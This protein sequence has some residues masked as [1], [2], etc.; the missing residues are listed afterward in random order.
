MITQEERKIIR[1]LAVRLKDLSLQPVMQERK[2]AWY[3]HNDL[4]STK[5]LL[6]VFPEG[7]WREII[8]P[9]MLLCEDEQARRMEWLLRARLYRAENINDDSAVEDI[10]EVE[11]IITDSGWGVRKAGERN[12][13]LGN[14]S[15]IDSA[16]GYTL[17]VWEKDFAFNGN[18]MPFNPLIEGP[19]DLKK[20]KAPLVSYDE[21]RTLEKFQIEQDIL[22]DILDVRLVEK[23]YIIFNLMEMYTDLRGLENVLYDLYEE[24]QMTHEAMHIFEEGFR[25]M[26]R[27][28]QEMDLLELNNDFCYVGTGGVGYT[29]ELPQND[30]GAADL[31]NLWALA[32]SQE[33][34]SVS[35]Q[36]H[37]EFVMQY[38]RRLLE[39]FGLAAYGCCEPLENKLENVLKAPNMRR[40]S[41]SPW[42][43]VQKCA[44]KLGRKAVY[45]WKP[46]PSYF[47]NNYNEEFLGGYVTDMLK[48][49]RENCV[50]IIMKDTHTCQK[51]PGRYRRWTDL[52]R[53][54]IEETGRY[55]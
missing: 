46:N 52:C 11:K 43:D 27:Q 18:A 33:F 35:P 32:E 23:K 30:K 24:P 29:R 15:T 21:K 4:K 10:W 55:E 3:Q 51:D 6:L 48:A 25:G 19:R 20:I 36:Q 50:E 31:K 41:I 26:I 40:I 16:I 34:T 45:S 38:E 47:I 2:E 14:A 28:Y 49:T 37:E 13:A 9:E 5:P 1:E 12:A 17:L 7:G 44:Q 39:P 22:G 53:R 54:C 42:A 8:T